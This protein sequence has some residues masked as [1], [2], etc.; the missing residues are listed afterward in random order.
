MQVDEM[1]QREARRL[2]KEGRAQ[3]IAVGEA[4]GEARGDTK[5]KMIM[6]RNLITKNVQDDIIKYCAEISD[7]ELKQ[8]KQELIRQNA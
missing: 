3:G 1:L 4:R 6:I 2:R 7:K 8:I 5:R